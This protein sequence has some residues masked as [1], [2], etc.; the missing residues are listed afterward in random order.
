MRPEILSAAKVGE[1][2]YFIVALDDPEKAVRTAETVQRLYPRVKVLARAR[3]RQHVHQ[4]LDAGAE[5]V[6]ETY[7]SSLEMTRRALEGLGLG[8]AQ[9]QRRIEQFMAHD[10]QVLAAQRL[11][12]GDRSKVMQTAQEARVELARLFESDEEDVEQAGVSEKR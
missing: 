9:A 4:L 3:N 11:V 10:E 5:P 8:S 2:E 12:R 6:R 7:Y 1:A